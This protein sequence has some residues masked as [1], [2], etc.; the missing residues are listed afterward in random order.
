[1]PNDDPYSE[2]DNIPRYGDTYPSIYSQRCSWLRALA[3]EAGFPLP[4]G[5]ATD[6]A[7]DGCHEVSIFAF[8]PHIDTYIDKYLLFHVASGS[9]LGL[10][11]Q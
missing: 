11:S 9:A 10:R 7:E 8:K 6:F 4:T 3:S 1:M 5:R 2:W